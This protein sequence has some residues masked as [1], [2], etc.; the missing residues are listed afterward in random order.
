MYKHYC[1]GDRV[2]CIKGYGPG[3]VPG[4]MGT[5]I[6]VFDDPNDPPIVHWDTYRGVR[7]DAG[8]RV[9]KGHG[10]FVYHQHIEPIPPDYGDFYQDNADVSVSD[11][12]GGIL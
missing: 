8:G 5:V 9:P 1:V 12:F 4:D 10:W 11:L 2:I 3:V 6:Q 7:H